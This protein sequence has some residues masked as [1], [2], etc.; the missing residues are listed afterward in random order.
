MSGGTNHGADWPERTGGIALRFLSQDGDPDW[1][2][3]QK[4]H[5]HPDY[6]KEEQSQSGLFHGARES[7]ES[8][9]GP[10]LDV[11]SSG[12]EGLYILGWLIATGV[13]SGIESAMLPV[14]GSLSVPGACHFLGG[15]QALRYDAT[16]CY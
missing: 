13:P 15:W 1:I 14:Q 5:G 12:G 2:A 16:S 10:P 3:V 7:R 9:T 4:R 8:G 6:R 11:P